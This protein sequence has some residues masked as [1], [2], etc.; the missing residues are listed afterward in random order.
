M[1]QHDYADMANEIGSSS[2]YDAGEQPLSDNPTSHDPA[3][4]AQLR[5]TEIVS[6]LKDRAQPVSEDDAADMW[7]EAT[8]LFFAYRR[9]L[10]IQMTDI[11]SI[12]IDR[13][14]SMMRPVLE[15]SVSGWV[16]A[17]TY[18]GNGDRWLAL[19][20]IQILRL[21][22]IQEFNIKTAS[23]FAMLDA[24]VGHLRAYVDIQYAGLRSDPA[25]ASQIL[26]RYSAE[27]DRLRQ[28]LAARG[29]SPRL[30]LT[31]GVEQEL[32]VA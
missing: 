16:Q 3:T 19:W 31:Q 4:T 21:A 27:L 26:A 7:H 29:A 9:K 22:L 10:Y 5:M 25:K 20:H 14:P 32:E 18:A 8:A 13:Y 17:E 6:Q 23:E 24:V 1:M 28:R 2:S 12:M 30:K 11:A 15:R